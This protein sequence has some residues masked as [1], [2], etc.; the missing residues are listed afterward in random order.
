MIRAFPKGLIGFDGSPGLVALGNGVI[1]GLLG[2]GVL[3]IELRVP[4]GVATQPRQFRSGIGQVRLGLQLVSAVRA[5]VD[6][7]QDLPSPHIVAAIEILARN[8][9]RHVG[10]NLRFLLCFDE[11][12]KLMGV[13]RILPFHL[14][15]L[16]RDNIGLR[17]LLLSAARESQHPSQGQ[18]HS[19]AFFQLLFKKLNIYLSSQSNPDDEPGIYAVPVREPLLPL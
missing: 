4:V 14:H 1:V 18:R 3:F 5:L 16:D 8:A 2:Y 7:K 9:A 19:K 10:R 15:G 11:A 13:R 6:G 17:L 12:R